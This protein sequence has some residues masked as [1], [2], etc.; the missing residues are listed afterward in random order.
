MINV[1]NGKDRTTLKS[2]RSDRKFFMNNKK[3]TLLPILYHTKG[4]LSSDLQ[5]KQF[6]AKRS[7]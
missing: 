7:N 4:G 5:V 6:V 3:N 1:K 2:M